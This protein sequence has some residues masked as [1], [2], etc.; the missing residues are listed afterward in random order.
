MIDDPQRDN[1]S[2]VLC[3]VLT[4]KPPYRDDEERTVVQAAKARLQPAYDSI[5]ACG[6]DEE[7]KRLCLECLAATQ[8]DR[9]NNAEE[10]AA[11]VAGALRLQRFASVLDASDAVHVSPAPAS[12][13]RH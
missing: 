4:G 8:Q 3:E 9:P 13:T 12:A 6:A 1:A 2:L 7:L 11:A 10:V 5:A